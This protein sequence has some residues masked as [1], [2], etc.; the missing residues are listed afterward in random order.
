MSRSVDNL[1]NA[2]IVVYKSAHSLSDEID[3]D[4]FENDIIETLEA[5]APTL[6]TCK[7]WDGNETRIILE[8][9]L[10]EV[11]LSEYNGLVSLS[12]RAKVENDN[13]EDIS[14]LS[15]SWLEQLRSRFEQLGDLIKIGTFSNG[16][17][18]FKSGDNKTFSSKEGF[19][20]W[21]N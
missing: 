2:E 18:M 20:E 4:L 13:Y 15:S 1:S 21:A 16:E 7:R 14:G 11:G 6:E 17:A 8:N 9:G 5:I 3:W 12:F 19:C 10:I